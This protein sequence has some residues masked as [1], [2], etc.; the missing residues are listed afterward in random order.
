MNKSQW[1]DL[2]A[3]VAGKGWPGNGHPYDRLPLYA[4]NKV[5]EAVWTLSRQ[6]A[7]LWVDFESDACELQARSIFR[8]AAPH[9]NRTQHA[10]V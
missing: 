9:G 5:T 2:S 8:Q 10:K 6:A 3:G 4:E 1:H 7:G